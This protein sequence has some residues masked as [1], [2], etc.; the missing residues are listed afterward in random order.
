MFL[1]MDISKHLLKSKKA[2][3]II[4]LICGLGI[5][6]WAPMVPFAK[7]RLHLDDSELGFLL[8]L[9]GLGAMVMMP[10][11][12]VL[13]NNLGSRKIIVVGALL[14]A[15]ILPFLLVISS[16]TWMSIALLI[17]GC[18]IGMIDVAM[19][20][21][22]VHVQNLYGRPI[23]SSLHGLFSVGGLLGSL[24]L[25]FLLKLGLDPV[26][27][28]IAISL[29]LIVLMI[30]Q[31]KNLFNFSFERETIGKFNHNEKT[32]KEAECFEWLNKRV[33]LLGFMC[34]SVFL[35][36]G[37]M[38]DWGS[39]F[40]RDLKNVTPE[41]TG[42][43][44]AAFS[45]A[46]A[47]MR[48][49]GDRIIE[50]LTHKIVV[51]VGC[52]ISVAGLLFIIFSMWM[53]FV[54]LGFIL[55]GTGASNIVPIFF[56]EGGRIK[57]ISPTVSISAITTIGYAGS[58]IGPALLGYIAYRFSLEITFGFIALMMLLVALIYSFGNK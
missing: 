46:M 32:S 41:F 31:Y 20:A 36:E 40:L 14:A 25:G 6:S 44:Y 26:S 7:D 52:L 49:F 1:M 29:M 30:S 13:M 47:I 19:N 15:F 51:V 21:H 39:I 27:S 5:S 43:G 18:A 28:A 9:L 17:F 16:Y 58:L 33:L 56:S 37:A 10:I 42:I 54:L 53:P 3:Q 4:F 55:L 11:S 38:L 24:G 12:G 8:L 48:L 35:S 2:T 23:M 45:M 22:G 50:R 34:F 57:G